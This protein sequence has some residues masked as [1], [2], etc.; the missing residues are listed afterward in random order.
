MGEA[1]RRCRCA[2]PD[3]VLLQPLARRAEW[4]KRCDMPIVWPDERNGAWK[5][6]PHTVR[7]ILNDA[8]RQG[9]ELAQ[10]ALARAGRDQ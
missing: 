1:K 10:A 7:R 5:R 6:S 3:G 8:A 4:C 9:A 2:E